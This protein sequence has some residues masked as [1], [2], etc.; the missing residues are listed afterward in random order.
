MCASAEARPEAEIDAL[1]RRAIS[2][3]YYALFHKICGLVAMRLVPRD[4]SGGRSTLWARAYRTLDHQTALTCARRIV[5]GTSNPMRGNADDSR[6]QPTPH[7]EG[8]VH[9]CEVFIF[10]HEARHSADYNPDE[11]FSRDD[12]E[13]MIE[14]AEQAIAKWESPAMSAQADHLVAELL[15]RPPRTPS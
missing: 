3:A 2:T 15:A 6:A 13:I 11:W 8:L 5:K 4:M 9:F 14:Q 10:L 12:A 1:V 7:D